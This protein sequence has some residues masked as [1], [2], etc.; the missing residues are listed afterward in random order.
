MILDSVPAMIFYK[1]TENRFIRSNQALAEA[2]GL[3]MKNWTGNRF[4]TFIL[5][6]PTITGKTTRK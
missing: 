3:P 1:D 5:P 4:L 6:R 2:M